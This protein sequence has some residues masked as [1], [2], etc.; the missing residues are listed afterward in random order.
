MERTKWNPYL[1]P[2]RGTTDT[3]EKEAAITY[4]TLSEYE[5]KVTD[6]MQRL[7]KQNRLLCH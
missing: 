4:S 6:A 3:V 5:S 2:N 1:S 7:R